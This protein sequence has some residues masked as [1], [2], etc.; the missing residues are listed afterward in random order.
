MRRRKRS[1]ELPRFCQEVQSQL[2]VL[3]AGEATG[4]GA[5]TMRRHLKRC[6]D[7]A[8]ELERQQQ[9]TSNLAALRADPPP[10]PPH[11]LDD[12]LARVKK[13]SWRE[14]AAIPARGAVSGARPELSVAFLTVGALASTGLGWAVWR[15]A[16]AVSSKVRTR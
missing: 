5:R 15:G 11:L 4:W 8:R 2:P 12:L 9:L 1:A 7:C 16:R 3:L 13:Q 6:P 10:P 14:R